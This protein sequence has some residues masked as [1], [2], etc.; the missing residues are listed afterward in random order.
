MVGGGRTTGGAVKEKTEYNDE[1]GV[2]EGYM[3]TC[4][5]RGGGEGEGGIGSTYTLYTLLHSVS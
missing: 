5:S 1:E 2:S 4:P 3:L